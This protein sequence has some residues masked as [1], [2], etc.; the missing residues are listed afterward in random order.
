MDLHTDK[1]AVEELTW[2][3]CNPDHAKNSKGEL[4]GDEKGKRATEQPVLPGYGVYPRAI[5]S[6][7]ICFD[8][9][10]MTRP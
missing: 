2:T 6:T 3:Q 7:W 8:P 10:G 5:I 9:E 1:R 4:R